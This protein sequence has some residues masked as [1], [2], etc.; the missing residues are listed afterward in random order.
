MRV[1]FWGVRGAF[2]S[3]Q[4]DTLRVGGNTPCVEVRDKH[5]EL[6]VLDAGHGLYW[7]GK[8][9]LAGPWGRGQG[10][11]TLLLSH[12]HWDHIQGFPF[13]VPAFIP[14]N[15]VVVWGPGGAE[16]QAVM[17]GQLDPTYSPL[18]SMENMPAQIRINE[19]APGQQ[20]TLGKLSVRHAMLPNGSHRTV[21]YRI[22]EG[23]RSLAYLPELA[24]PRGAVS[25]AALDLAR[26][27]DV[28]IHETY[29]SPEQLAAGGASLGG[30]GAPAASGHSSFTQAVD[31][32][33]AAGAKRLLCF[34]HHPDRPDDEV[35]ALLEAERARI[36]DAELEVD[37]AREGAEF[38][39]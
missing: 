13:F 22:R 30:P 19:L 39:L 27:C 5:D 14:G 12:T 15:S 20:L 35:E 37:T 6:V 38:D 2:A 33:L 25:Q 17:A 11:L 3:T 8:Q 18:V 16:L 24:H 7:L 21:G 4:A 32:A 26:G 1:R 10:H 36:G 34:Y 31:L 23:E 29:Y 9:L 28:V